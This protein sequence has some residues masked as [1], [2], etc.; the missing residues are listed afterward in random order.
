MLSC[1]K[2]PLM[3]REEYDFLPQC[4][5]S[6]F[7]SSQHCENSL[8]RCERQRQSLKEELKV[9]FA[10]VRYE[11]SGKNS[12]KIQDSGGGNRIK[13]VRASCARSEYTRPK[14]KV[15]GRLSFH[16]VKTIALFWLVL[17]ILLLIQ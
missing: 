13:D 2:V 16:V 10:V 12:M 3:L 14:I 4:F 17:L 7:L 5:L 1:I 15:I 6:H 11:H 8:K 9:C